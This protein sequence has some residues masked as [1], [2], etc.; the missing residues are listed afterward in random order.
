M[1]KDTP[2]FIITKFLQK[3]TTQEE[4][5]ELNNWLKEDPENENLLSEAYN[6]YKITHSTPQPLYPDTEVAWKKINQKITSQVPAKRTLSV[7]IRYVAAVAAIFI[8]AFSYLWIS[9]ESKNSIISQQYT[10]VVTPMGQKTMVVLSD[11]SIVWLNSGS[12][13]K[14]K[15]N[16][17]LQEREVVLKGEAYFDVKKNA[18]KPFRVKTGILNVDVHGT[19]FNIKNHENDDFQEITVA[20][21]RVGISDKT[22]EIRQL[23]YGD[24]A[25]FNKNTKI[26]VFTKSKPEIVSAWKNNELIFDNTPMEEA[27]KYMERWYGVKITLDKAMKGKHNYTFKIKTESLRELLEMIK[28]MTPLEYEINGKDVKIRYAN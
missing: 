9:N 6:I 11:S 24:Q 3:K 25:L 12:S 13:L 28:V 23:T 7:R 16:F 1:K 17:N 19:A 20:E 15:G 27:I 18:S 14:Y 5:A 26:I 4:L 8:V 2:W 10:E 22:G 21:G